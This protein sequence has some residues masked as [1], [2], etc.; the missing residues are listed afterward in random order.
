M[1]N[2]LKLIT[3]GFIVMALSSFAA[4]ENIAIVGTGSGMSVLKAIGEAFSRD[5]PGVTIDVPD[6]IGSGGGIKAVGN[7]QN[8]IG[9]VARAIKDKEKHYGLS[10]VPVTKMPI[11]ST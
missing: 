1:K 8:V 10:Y 2:A 9:R 7:D 5:N 3:I 11:F 4:A 6:S